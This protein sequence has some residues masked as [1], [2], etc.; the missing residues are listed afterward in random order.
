MKT[1]RELRQRRHKG[2]RKN[3]NGTA[4]VPRLNVFRSNKHMYAQLIDD[5]S[6]KT[7]V[8]TNDAAAK[9]GTP[10]EKAEQ[11]GAELA[12]VAKAKKISKAVFDRSGYKYHGRVRALAE[13]ARAGGLKF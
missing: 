2:V 8:S 4:D 6:G 3:V 13:G 10:T 1:R 11:V 9:K 12:K 7:L 5:V